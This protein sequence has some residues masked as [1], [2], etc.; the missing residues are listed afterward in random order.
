MKY[1]AFVFI[2]TTSLVSSFAQ[3]S[4]SYRKCIKKASAQSEMN[5]CAN[6]EAARVEAE[7]SETYH[8]LLSMAANQPEAADK[9]KA[10]EGAWIA[11]RDAYMEA[12]Y[13][14]RDKQ[15]EYGSIYPMEFDLRRAKLAQ[16]HVAALRDLIEQYGGDQSATST[17][18]S[19]KAR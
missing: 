10:S 16:Q 5:V 15:G 7:L 17:T 3:N 2:V 4:E 9:I 6:E 18:K 19:T 8:R 13:P 1:L 11:Y 12:M 14:A